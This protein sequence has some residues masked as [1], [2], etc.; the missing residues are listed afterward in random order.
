MNEQ[1]IEHHGV[2]GMKWGVR[3]YQPYPKGYS[4]DGKEV[5]EAAKNNVKTAWKELRKRGG[6]LNSI[7]RK[8]KK[9]K[10]VSDRQMTAYKESKKI[11]DRAVSEI[12]KATSKVGTNQVNKIIRRQE[13]KRSII[14]SVVGTVAY[15]AGLAACAS[16]GLP[17]GAAPRIL[18]IVDMSSYSARKYYNNRNDGRV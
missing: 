4:D 1:Y 13:F 3:R 9:G 11:A 10:K 2:L 15:N 5:G 17:V 18:P 14:G 16:M 6:Y 8:I 12:N 7:D